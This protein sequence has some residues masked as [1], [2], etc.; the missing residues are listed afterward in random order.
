[1]FYRNR[2]KTFSKTKSFNNITLSILFILTFLLIIFNKT[3]YLIVNKIKSL[4]ID[5]VTPITTII[6]Y[7]VKISNK[8][9]NSINQIR[10]LKDENMRFKEE[11]IRL[12]KWHTLAVKNESENLAY[13]KI[14]NSTSNDNKIV[15]TALVT[16]KSPNIYART[17]VI[18]A[19]LNDG[20]SEDLPVIN[21]RGL[22]GKIIS[23][24]KNKSKILLIN[25]QNSSIPVK[26]ISNNF[27][28][29][30]K[31]SID[32]KYLVS[33]FIKGESKP[34][35]GDI[36]VTSGNTKTFPQ[37]ILVGKIIKIDDSSFIVIPYV[38]FSN[39]SYVQIIDNK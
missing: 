35:I 26:T 11:I 24:T 14:L 10:F 37:N 17:I 5:I 31:G 28:A 1:M 7:P 38:D 21:A 36:L 33:S 4:G 3:D 30:V 8:V 19:G 34:K 23:L 9:I 13:K 12:K 6:T 29:I 18:N 2:I 22:V 32:K 39:L 27:F 25:D 16:S 20:I 15:K